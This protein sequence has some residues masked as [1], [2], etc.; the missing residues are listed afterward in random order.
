MAQR[1]QLLPLLLRAA[2]QAGLDR[3]AALRAGGRFDERLQIDVG[4]G[5]DLDGEADRAAIGC[6]QFDGMRTR[7]QRRVQKPRA[8]GNTHI[9]VS[10]ITLLLQADALIA[11]QASEIDIVPLDIG[12]PDRQI[13]EGLIYIQP[14]AGGKLEQGVQ[15]AAVAELFMKSL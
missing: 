11:V 6:S 7:R 4:R 3:L 10:D 1:L 2:V 9:R 8:L 5:Q 12:P 13:K 14:A 15:A